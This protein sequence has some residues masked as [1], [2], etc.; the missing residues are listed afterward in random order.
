MGTT[1]RTVRSPCRESADNPILPHLSQDVPVDLKP[2]KFHDGSVACED[3]PSG[4]LHECFHRASQGL[5][6]TRTEAPFSWPDG[7][8]GKGSGQCANSPCPP[9]QR[10]PCKRRN[11]RLRLDLCRQVAAAKEKLAALQEPWKAVMSELKDCD[12]QLATLQLG[13]IAIEYPAGEEV[14]AGGGRNGAVPE[15]ILKTPNPGELE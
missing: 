4:A 13:R 8:P 6:S 11:W 2:E 14:A 3:A 7:A 12:M 1:Q 15:T 10:Q 9:F 5:R